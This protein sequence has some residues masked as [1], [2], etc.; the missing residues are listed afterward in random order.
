MNSIID[1]IDR[2][3][4]LDGQLQDR[5]TR[6]KKARLLRRAVQAR[7]DWRCHICGREFCNI[8][9]ATVDHVIPLST[10]VPGEQQVVDVACR[11]CN[12]RRSNVPITMYRMFQ[13]LQE[14]YPYI[15]NDEMPGSRESRRRTRR[16]SKRRA[17][18]RRKQQCNPGM[19][20]GMV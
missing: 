2:V 13:M 7:R 1:E 16:A 19:N 14:K 20:Q 15:V 9:E 17:L 8:T 4:R 18:I 6:S 11:Q 12:K 3:L 10:K 5:G